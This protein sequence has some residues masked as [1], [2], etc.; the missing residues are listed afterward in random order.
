MAKYDEYA[1]GFYIT[2]FIISTGQVFVD[3]GPLDTKFPVFNGPVQLGIDEST[4]QTGICVAAMDGTPIMLIDVINR[5]LPKAEVYLTL[6]RRWINNVFPKMDIK[7][8]IYE[9]INQNAPQQ[10][11]RKRLM[12]VVNIIE[13]YA[14]TC[15]SDIEL[16][17]INNKVW[18]KH[19]LSDSRYDGK[20]VKTELVKMAVKEE[21]ERQYSNLVHYKRY[22]YNGD[23]T[24]ALGIIYGYSKECFID[25]KC[26]KYKINNTMKPTPLRSY[27][28]E[29]YSMAEI[30][31]KIKSGEIKGVKL[32]KYNPN[33][34]LEDN[35]L[36]AVNY[37]PQGVIIW[38]L[39]DSK[40]VVN[41]LKFDANTELTENSVILIRHLT[42]R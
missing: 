17:C 41:I 29:Y 21:A 32:A 3:S 14:D 26:T 39:T 9:E 4:T 20:R 15:E 24:D 13:S 33:M 19:F 35:C 25:N 34:T 28:K 38:G 10:Y 22:Y 37:N 42:K 8:I 23:S 30:T 5:S 27:L 7:R 2:H 16:T 12:Q 6:L 18:K 1:L 36:R 11:A 31:N 40:K